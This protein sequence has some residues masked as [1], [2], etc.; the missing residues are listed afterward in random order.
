[1]V[2]SLTNQLSRIDPMPNWTSNL[3][4]LAV[5]DRRNP[6]PF[7]TLDCRPAHAA[8]CKLS[9]TDELA[10]ALAALDG[11]QAERSGDS[12]IADG[13]AIDCLIETRIAPAA[14]REVG[15]DGSERFDRWR[16]EASA[17]VITATRRWTGC[18]VHRAEYET[19]GD[20]L[21]VR[22]L[23][24]QNSLVYRDPRYALAEFTFLLRTYFE[25]RLSPFPIPP[26]LSHDDSRKIALLGWKTHGA[27]A[28]FA[29]FL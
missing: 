15:A 20:S 5:G 4:W 3:A 12:A 9:E 17:G 26:G 29:A 7:E 10:D 19:R 2:L 1:V 23:T 6:F 14:A 8:L 11:Q 13:L 22:R 18:D 25:R 28:N 24:S 27:Q 21:R 16:L